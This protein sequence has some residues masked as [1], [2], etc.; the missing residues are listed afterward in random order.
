MLVEKIRNATFP[1]LNLKNFYI[2]LNTST[3][4]A[5]LAPKKR[6]GKLEEEGAQGDLGEP[7]VGHLE[8]QFEQH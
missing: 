1:L 8:Q 3:F 2:I 5:C 7:S 6:R 4:K